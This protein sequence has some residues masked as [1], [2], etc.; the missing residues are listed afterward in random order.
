[1]T[2]I[3]HASQD[4]MRQRL[5]TDKLTGQ[6]GKLTR[7]E[8]KRAFLRMPFLWPTD[9]P[10]EWQDEARKKMQHSARKDGQSPRQF[11][12]VPT[13]NLAAMDET[14][15]AVARL[16]QI[17]GEHGPCPIEAIVSHTSIKRAAL[18]RALTRMEA[19]GDVEREKRAIKGKFNGSFYYVYSLVAK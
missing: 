8:A 13:N 6:V 5:K 1:M 9:Y 14:E 3:D 17:L 12:L 19:Q 4:Y 15:K 2:P 18:T 7:S 11:V 16:F 10:D